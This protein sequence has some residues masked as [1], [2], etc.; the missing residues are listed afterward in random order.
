MFSLIDYADDILNAIRTLISIEETFRVLSKEY[1]N[2]GLSFNPQKSEIL[3]YNS[4]VKDSVPVDAI[5]GTY[6]IKSTSKIMYLDL[7]ICSDLKKKLVIA[8]FCCSL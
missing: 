3:V 4:R 8:L 7:P 2:I 6:T 1:G 5:L